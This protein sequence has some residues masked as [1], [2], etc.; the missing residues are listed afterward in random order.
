VQTSISQR[1]TGIIKLNTSAGDPPSGLVLLERLAA[2]RERQQVRGALMESRDWVACVRQSHSSHPTLIYFQSIGIGAGWPAALGAIL[3]VALL[4]EH[5]IDDD[6]L[7]GPAVL[8]RSEGLRMSRDLGGLAGVQPKEVGASEAEL[9]QTVH[10]LASSGYPLRP[11]I[12]YGLMT[13]QRAEYCGYVDAL[14]DH[15]GKPT[16]V[17]VRKA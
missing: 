15:L 7:Y 12:D 16:A 11:D 13:A 9:R 14:A 8:L 5:C 6:S 17:L 3:D 2:L 4:S 10:R 1:D